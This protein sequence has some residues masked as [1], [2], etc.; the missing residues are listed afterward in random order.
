M[1][2]QFPTQLSAASL[3]EIVS[4]GEK[5]PSKL[6]SSLQKEVIER[7]GE[8]PSKPEA[9]QIKNHCK[10][11]AGTG[12]VLRQRATDQ[13]TTE[14]VAILELPATLAVEGRIANIDAVGIKTAIAR[15]IR[16][17]DA[18][19]ALCAK[20]NHPK[21]VDSVQPALA[22]ASGPFVPVSLVEETLR[23]HG[24]TERCSACEAVRSHWAVENQLHWSPDVQFDEDR[25]RVR[26]DY[27]SS[28]LVVLRHI[29]RNLLRFNNPR[30]GCIKSKR[31]LA[32]SEDRFR[33]DLL[34]V[35]DM[36]VRSPGL[37]IGVDRPK[38]PRYAMGNINFCFF[39][40]SYPKQ[41]TI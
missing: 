19:Y 8:Y 1:K 6:Q 22:R 29:V 17:H 3:L 39:T 25:P 32:C 30:K 35:Y 38:R 24:R 23:G 37:C 11:V 7:F 9:R 4:Q 2:Q 12:L 13:T 20:D 14:I 40:A 33:A 5:A 10:W 41:I 16:G 28:N 15:T 27:A 21:L 26:T 18:D 36:K 31:I 34:G